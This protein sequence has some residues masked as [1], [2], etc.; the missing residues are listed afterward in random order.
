M[1]SRL[2]RAGKMEPHNFE[3]LLCQ[4][5]EEETEPVM[6]DLFTQK[7]PDLFGTHERRRWY[8]KETEEGAEAAEQATEE[9][10]AQK[11]S[12][13]LTRTTAELLQKSQSQWEA[14]QRDQSSLKKELAS[15]SEDDP[16]RR[17]PRLRR[18]LKEV[19]QKLEK[20]QAQRE[21]WQKQALHYSDI[22]E[23]YILVNPKPRKTLTDL[24][25]DFFLHHRCQQLAS[26]TYGWGEEGKSPFSLP[27]RAP[28]D[29][30]ALQAS[31][32]RGRHPCRT[33]S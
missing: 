26:S 3:E 8:L 23:F 28:Q 22:Y 4:V 20:L 27:G 5:A 30:A 12:Q 13:F 1:V 33:P 15:L 2:V 10:A 19:E 16:E 29:S 32:Q 24:L 7:K 9:A 14:L 18:A 11:L 17:R 25:E 31:D 21:E 6:Q